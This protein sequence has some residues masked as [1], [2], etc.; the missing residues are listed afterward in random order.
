L[1]YLNALPDSWTQLYQ[2]RAIIQQAFWIFAIIPFVMAHYRFWRETISSG[3]VPIVMLTLFIV[4]TL[5]IILSPNKAGEMLRV[6]N[7][8]N[9]AIFFQLTL[10]HFLIGG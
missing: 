10:S 1:S 9:A 2:P 6:T 5:T 8:T 3:K 4:S 7:L